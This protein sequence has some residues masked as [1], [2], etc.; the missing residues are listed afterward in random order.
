[1]TAMMICTGIGM[2]SSDNET[3]SQG[4]DIAN[5]S[6]AFIDCISTDT[7]SYRNESEQEYYCIKYRHSRWNN[8]YKRKVTFNFITAS[9]LFEKK[10][11]LTHTFSTASMTDDQNEEMNYFIFYKISDQ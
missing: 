2:V 7:Q 8:C 3:L 4:S 11:I 1:V 6:M 9:K 5:P 10:W